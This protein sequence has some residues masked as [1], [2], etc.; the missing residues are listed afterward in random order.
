VSG[1][2]DFGSMGVDNV[3]CDVA[4]L[5]GSLVRRDSRL[6]RVGLA[7]YGAIRP[8]SEVESEL[9]RAFDAS[10][11]LLGALNWAAWALLESRVF[12]EPQAVLQRIDALMSRL[13]TTPSF[14]PSG[15]GLVL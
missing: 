15:R 9:V 10:G 11:A 13:E 2:I 4:R 1:L 14:P 8:L 7:S 5:L 3:S 6:W 12:E